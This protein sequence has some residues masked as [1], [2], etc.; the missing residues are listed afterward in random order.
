MAEFATHLTNSYVQ[1]NDR[2]SG[3]NRQNFNGGIEESLVDANDTTLGRPIDPS[4]KQDDQQQISPAAKETMDRIENTIP[5]VNV[6]DPNILQDHNSW[7]IAE[8]EKDKEKS[9]PAEI[10]K[11]MAPV[12][13]GSRLGPWGAAAGAAAGALYDLYGPKK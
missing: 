7:R 2:N 6:P 11:R 13:V 12:I 1:A 3:E 9:L 8:L 5:K 10:A 4:A